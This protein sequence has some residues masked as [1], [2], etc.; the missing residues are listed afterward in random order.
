VEEG[1]QTTSIAKR[2]PLLRVWGFHWYIWLSLCLSAVREGTDKA[3]IAAAHPGGV[4]LSATDWWLATRL[5]GSRIASLFPS[6]QKLHPGRF[7]HPHELRPFLS[8]TVDGAHLLLAEYHG[9]HI[10]RVA[11]TAK[12]RQLGNMLICGPTGSGKS[13]HITS[14]LLT[15]PGSCV[16]YDI[17]G[18]LHRLTA[19]YRATLGPVYVLD[20]TGVGNQYDPFLGRVSESKL[21]A[22]ANNLLF[23]P[24]EGEGRAFV[25]KGMKMLT[26]VSL[27]GREV[28]RKM[29]KEDAA[30]LPFIGSTADLGLNRAA[31]VISAIS[32]DLAR[33][34][35]DEDYHPEKDY[36]ENRYLANSWESVTARL[37]PL[38]T[39]EVRRILGGSDFTG[40]D[41]MR[42]ENPVTV[43]LRVPEEDLLALSPVT[44]LVLDSLINELF[45]T[46]KQAEKEG[47][48]ERCR[49]VLF[50]IDE[51]GRTA[52]LA[53]LPD[54]L[55]TVRSR[56]ISIV[57]AIQ[58]LSQLT[59]LYPSREDDVL[60]NCLSHIYYQPFSYK[61]AR[62]LAQWLGYT[63]GFAQS[64]STHGETETS[65]SLSEREVPLMTPDEMRLIGEDAV[66]CFQPGIRPFLARRMDWHRFSLLIRRTAIAPPPV[67]L[68][69]AL[70]DPLPVMTTP[71]TGAGQQSEPEPGEYWRLDRMLLRGRKAASA[72]RSQ[73]TSS[74]SFSSRGRDTP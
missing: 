2:L 22:A 29:G 38:L 10:L 25:E 9:K 31:A 35:L 13:Q 40:R 57:V 66:L 69:P 59:A 7:A 56:G 5:L 30:L 45:T 54:H 24:R 19:G 51:A 8:P 33:R 52:S 18:E 55:T 39:E 44:R 61:M 53:T 42:A 23:D 67:P 62:E 73:H 46:Y 32:P 47:T 70:P 63:S 65:Q 48:Q 27:A 20:P 74:H 58:T 21:Y 71:P 37:Y 50:L 11:T 34:F 17:K 6:E 28:N 14:Q 36:T 68:L 3:A 26:I 72:T 4:A 64:T 41:L 49:K 43:Y 60:N 1:I 15:F 12:R 16:V